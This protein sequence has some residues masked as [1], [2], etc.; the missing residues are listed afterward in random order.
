MSSNICQEECRIAHCEEEM[1]YVDGILGLLFQE[2]LP[3]HG[4]Q[5]TVLSCCHVPRTI[6]LSVGT[7]FLDRSPP[8]K[9]FKPE[10]VTHTH[11]Q[12]IFGWVLTVCCRLSI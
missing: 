6:E 10:D 5:V 2:C 1:I 4:A 11:L 8:H 3:W 7:L 12:S 9:P